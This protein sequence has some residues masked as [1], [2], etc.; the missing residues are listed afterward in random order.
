MHRAFVRIRGIVTPVRQRQRM[1][2]LVI[3]DAD[4]T[5]IAHTCVTTR[6][7]TRKGPIH[8]QIIQTP[9]PRATRRG[10]QR[11]ATRRAASSTMA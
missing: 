5:A 7:T 9:A 2:E 1:T 8:I 11:P 6:L 4:V 3:Q 10:L